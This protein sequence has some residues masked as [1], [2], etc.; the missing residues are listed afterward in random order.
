MQWQPEGAAD[1]SWNHEEAVP[2]AGAP[3]AQRRRQRLWLMLISSS[4]PLLSGQSLHTAG[5]QSA[6]G[7]LGNRVLCDAGVS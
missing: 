2:S 1:G 5:K 6:C 3:K 4:L 7:S